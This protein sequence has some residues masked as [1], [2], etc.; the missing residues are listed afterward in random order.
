MGLP[1]VSII[2]VTHNSSKYIDKLLADLS[3]L[4]Y[5]RELL[6]VIFVDNA[7]W[8]DTL[9]LIFDYLKKNLEIR[10]IRVLELK[11]NIGFPAGVNVGITYA[12]KTWNPRYIVIMN[13]D[14]RI[15]NKAF[16]KESILLMRKYKISCASPIIFKLEEN[17]DYKI[18][19]AL[20]LLDNSGTAFM[21]F[22][23][24]DYDTVN[25][26]SSK[27]TLI[28]VLWITFALAII[29]SDA[30]RKTGLLRSNLFLYYEDIEYSLRLM[31]K[32]FQCYSLLIPSV[33]HAESES[34]RDPE[35]SRNIRA[36]FVRNSLI[37]V[38]EYFGLI[39]LLLRIVSYIVETFI[40]KDKAI[41]YGLRYFI[42]DLIGYKIRITLTLRVP[43]MFIIKKYS[44]PIL[45]IKYKSLHPALRAFSLLGALEYLK[46]IKLVR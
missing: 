36:L 15:L 32:G 26:L 40:F 7:S 44:T 14:V 29:D 9:R 2:V 21:G 11:N 25:R 6:Q 8:D 13:P 1:K 19:W 5:P 45:V 3:S 10:N 33:A 42:K 16:L 24:L 35:L 31:L 38:A 37:V 17:R 4:D 27:I 28:P 22:Y 46:A 34:L 41:T 18:Q 39:P 20:G 12:L 30:V 43:S 23:D